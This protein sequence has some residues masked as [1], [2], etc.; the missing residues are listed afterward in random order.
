MN[1]FNKQSDILVGQ[2]RE[3]AQKGQTVDMYPLISLFTLDV[4]CGKCLYS[5]LVLSSFGAITLIPYFAMNMSLP[6]F[7][8]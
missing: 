8:Y 7:C 3:I 1:V 4:V 6:A 5:G 2:L